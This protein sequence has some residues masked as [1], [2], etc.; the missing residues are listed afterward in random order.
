MARRIGPFGP[1]FDQLFKDFRHTAFRLEVLQGYSVPYEEEPIRRF[2]ANEPP[3]ADPDKEQWLA[4]I[5]AAVGAGKLMQRVH[6]VVEPLSP[7]LRYELAWEYS[8]NVAAG[9]DVRIVAIQ[10]GS[11]PN[12][13]PRHDYWLFDSRTLCVMDYDDEG[14]LL[15]A[16]LVDDPGEIVQHNAWRDAALHQGVPYRDYVRRHHDLPLLMAS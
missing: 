9:E 11:W 10:A 5:R 12:E 15:G 1:E 4:F 6:V 14:R 2:L 8:C 7:Y 3:P 16:D 13:M